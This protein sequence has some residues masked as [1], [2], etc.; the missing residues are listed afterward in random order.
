MHVLVANMGQD[1][2]V[3]VSQK[4]LSKLIGCSVETVKRALS[5]LTSD[6]WIEAVRLNGP[7]TVN[8]YVINSRVAWSRSRAD[9]KH[10]VFNARVI[11][12]FDDQKELESADLRRIPVLYPNEQQLP[13]GEGEPPPSQPLIDGMEPDLPTRNHT[14]GA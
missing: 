6:N 4:T 12:D 8:A 9:L 5:D 13:S 11:A 3:V 14:D 7:G 1:N 2:A 10:S